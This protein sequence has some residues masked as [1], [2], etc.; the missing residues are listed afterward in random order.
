[1][2]LP[3]P[4]RAIGTQQ[5]RPSKRSAGAATVRRTRARAAAAAHI[6]QFPRQR[7]SRRAIRSL[8][9]SAR[10]AAVL[11]ARA[12]AGSKTIPARSSCWHAVER[13]ERTPAEAADRRLQEATPPIPSVQRNTLAAM[14]A[15]KPTQAVRSM[16]V[17][18]A[19][20]RLGRAAL[21]AM[22]ATPAP[23]MPADPAA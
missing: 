5:A 18:A 6:A 16:A 9:K 22:A 23:A 19:V 3:G 14:A 10:M 1:M 15:R 8:F 4:F 11:E 12:T 21:A 13:T 2:V 7:T 17:R 20:A